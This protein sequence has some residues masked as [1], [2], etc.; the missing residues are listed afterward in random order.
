MIS[1]DLVILPVFVYRCSLGIVDKVK[2][3][4]LSLKENIFLPELV[5]GLII[6]YPHKLCR[7]RPRSMEV[8]NTP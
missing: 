1:A 2:T 5:Y 7:V 6:T 3:K 8:K 4:L